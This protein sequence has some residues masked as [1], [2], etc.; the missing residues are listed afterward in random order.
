MKPEYDIRNWDEERQTLR[1][2]L[3]NQRI[4]SVPKTV[5][6]LLTNSKG[7]KGEPG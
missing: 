7:L 2:M 1:G 6:V 3:K 5:D 4:L